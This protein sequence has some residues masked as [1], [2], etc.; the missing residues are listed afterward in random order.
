LLCYLIKD[1]SLEPDMQ[2]QMLGQVVEL[3]W[4]EETFLVLQALLERQLE[5]APEMFGIL[6][7]KLCKEGLAATTSMAYAKLML[8]VMTKYQANLGVV[9]HAFNPSTWEAEA[10][11]SLDTSAWAWPWS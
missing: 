5:M 10:G 1:N 3:A 11:R 2:V 9:A 8:T 6:M 7:E 4:R